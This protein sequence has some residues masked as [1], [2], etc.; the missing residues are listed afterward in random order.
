MEHSTLLTALGVCYYHS[1]TWQGEVNAN[2]SYSLRLT[3][4]SASHGSV[5][6]SRYLYTM[7]IGA[8]GRGGGTAALIRHWRWL[9]GT[10][11]SDSCCDDGT[12]VVGWCLL[13]EHLTELTTRSTCVVRPSVSQDGRWP[14]QFC[15]VR[16]CSAPGDDVQTAVVIRERAYG[17]LQRATF[18]GCRWLNLLRKSE[19]TASVGGCYYRPLYWSR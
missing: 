3:W 1:S 14:D 5:C 18:V 4:R 13:A 7:M 15:C 12:T 6:I 17:V 16:A 19:P 2:T 11:R 9:V 8:R 10:G